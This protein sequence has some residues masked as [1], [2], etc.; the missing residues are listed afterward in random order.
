MNKLPC[1]ASDA[2]T[3]RRRGH[4]CLPIHLLPLLWLVGGV[5][6]AATPPFFDRR[7]IR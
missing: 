3:E 5:A 1:P 7:R 6:E 2:T 4:G